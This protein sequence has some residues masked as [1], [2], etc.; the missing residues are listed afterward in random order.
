MRLTLLLLASSALWAQ[1]GDAAA[2]AERARGLVVAGKVEE[3]IPLYRELV[4]VYPND[5]AILVNLSIA[6]FKARRYQDAAAHAAS[7]VSLQPESL[8]A[9]LFL[10]SSYVELGEYSRAIAP[11]EKVIA[12]QPQDRNARL[13]LAEA[14]LNLEHYAD[15]ESQFQEARVL[16]PDNPKV[17]YGLGRTF[18]ALTENV[19]HQMENADPDS[20]YWHALLADLYFKQRRYGSAFTHYRLAIEQRAGLRGLHSALATVYRR[21]GHAAWAEIE[22]QRERQA[23]LDC[24]AGGLACDFAAGR[25]PEIIQS[26]RSE[27]TPEARY[28]ACRAYAQMAR[29]SYSTL[30]RLPTSLETHLHAAKAFDVQGL[31]REAAGE[32]R[33]ALKIAPGDARIEI[34]LAWSLF[35]A[36]EFR[37]ALAV[38]I[39]PMKKERDSRELNFLYGASLV[40]SDEPEKAIAPLEAA[41]RFDE[42]FLPAQAALGQALLQAG[43]PSQAIPHLKAALAGDEDASTHFQLLRAYQL[44]GHAELAAQAQMEYQKALRIA[45]TKERLEEGGAITAP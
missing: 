7:A 11:L 18:D 10:G 37:L 28:W 34:A 5:A 41:I 33:E 30:G 13:M 17:W 23:P 22:E 29:E 25:F 21:T 26:T 4:R 3:A 44:M 12:T 1:V 8:A 14:L 43:K 40:N 24:S 9:N 32:W 35:R 19:F 31:S 6:E 45:E 2:K 39:E 42:S 20:P 16:A 27:T 15:A 36:H 38:L